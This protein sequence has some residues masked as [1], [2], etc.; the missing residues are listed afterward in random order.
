MSSTIAAITDLPPANDAGDAV[1]PGRDIRK[2]HADFVAALA[3]RPPRPIARE[4]DPRDFTDR[5]LCCEALIERVKLHL[6]EL[7][8]EAAGNDPG[9]FITDAELPAAIDAHLADLQSDIAGA[10]EQIAERLREDRY[11]GCSRGP[12][13][14]RRGA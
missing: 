2:A 9:R 3:S 5:A 4:P 13:Y 7:I 11:G 6:T 1:R 12:F 10:L 14:R 8:D